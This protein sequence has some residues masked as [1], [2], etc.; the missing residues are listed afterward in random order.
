MEKIIQQ[1]RWSNIGLQKGD[2]RATT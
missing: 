1:T 2:V